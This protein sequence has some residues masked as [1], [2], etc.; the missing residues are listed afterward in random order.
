MSVQFS[1]WDSRLSRAFCPELARPGWATAIGEIVKGAP[2]AE[3]CRWRS[4][5]ADI[6]LSVSFRARRQPGVDP[7]RKVRTAE[8]GR[9]KSAPL[10][11]DDIDTRLPHSG[12]RGHSGPTTQEQRRVRPPFPAGLVGCI[13]HP[14]GVMSRHESE[15]GPQMRFY[16]Q[17]HKHYCGIDLHARHDVP[18]RPGRR[19]QQC[20]CRVTSSALP[21][22][23]V[24]VKS[25]PRRSGGGRGVHV[26]LVL[27]RR[28][29]RARGHPLRARP[30]AVHEGDPRRQ[31]QERPDRRPQDRRAAQGRVLSAGLRLPPEM[32]ET[33]D[34]LRRRITSCASAPS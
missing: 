33:R 6:P 1:P 34:L 23:P 14:K 20:C 18:V 2:L 31:G 4:S 16:T 5:G 15:R 3:C 21:G 28:P 11:R 25:L 26:R 27:A 32:R 13:Y 8:S 9:T 12:R 29:V 30:R 7:K 10:E 17:Q 24:A 19:R 22:V